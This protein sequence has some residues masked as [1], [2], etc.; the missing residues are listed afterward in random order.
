MNQF[1]GRYGVKLKLDF[2][3]G[4][5]ARNGPRVQGRSATS[6]GRRLRRRPVRTGYRLRAAEG[7]RFVELDATPVSSGVRGRRRGVGDRSCCS[8]HGFRQP[9]PAVWVGRN[10]H[11]EPE[12]PYS[13][14]VRLFGDFTVCSQGED[15]VGGLVY[16]PPISEAQ[17]KGN[18]TYDGVGSSLES[19]Y[20]GVYGALLS[21]DEELASRDYD[22]QEIEFTFESPAGE[23]LFILQKRVMV[24]ENTSDIPCFDTPMDGSVVPA[25]IGIGV[26]GGAYAGRVAV[27]SDQI[28]ELL[29]QN[30]DENI[31]AF[32]ARYGSRGHHHDH[33]CPGDPNSPWSARPPMRR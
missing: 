24:S 3:P 8:A 9:G 10:L 1:K 26:S 30:P 12:E 29:E 5:D 19:D 20:P 17:R 15:L 14:Q 18:P 16:P 2:T 13:R 31:D 32:K 4:A 7:S 22:P 27:N 23:D 11:P 33:T 6:T 25:A 28:Q 21:A